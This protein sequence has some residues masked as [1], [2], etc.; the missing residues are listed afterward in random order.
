MITIFCT[1]NSCKK[2]GPTLPEDT[3][4][5][6]PIA[7]I[8]EKDDVT[9][10][11]IVNDT[12]IPNDFTKTYEVE[13]IGF[14]RNSLKKGAVIVDYRGTGNIWIV[15]EVHPGKTNANVIITAIQGTLD[16]LFHNCTIEASTPNNR[17]KDAST[18]PAKLPSGRF[19][20][21]GGDEEYDFAI[22][23]GSITIEDIVEE[24]GV[25]LSIIN[26][27]I[28][29]NFTDFDVYH[30]SSNTFNVTIPDGKV[31][32]NNAIDIKMEYKPILGVVLGVAGTIGSIKDLECGVYSDVDADLKLNFQSTTN[33]TMNLI[34]PIEVE[35]GSYTTLVPAPPLTFR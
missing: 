6:N 4:S 22:D 18:N 33:G 26:N 1:V 11:L 12:I 28:T 32:V 34:D 29:V 27:T 24:D 5:L 9:K 7:I 10:D 2:D 14:E 31:E 25:N 15:K 19:R 35:I 30:N 16:V 3:P 13:L 23:Y 21:Y 17:T 20:M 8:V